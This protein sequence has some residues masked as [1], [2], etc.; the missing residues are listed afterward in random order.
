MFRQFQRWGIEVR[1]EMARIAPLES[2]SFDDTESNGS[3]K[4]MVT[5]LEMFLLSSF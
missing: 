2:N 4:A 1:F 3:E 5:G